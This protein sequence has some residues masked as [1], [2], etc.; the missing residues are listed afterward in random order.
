MDGWVGVR[1]SAPLCI[2]QL[3]LPGLSEIAKH[4]RDNQHKLERRVRTNNQ[5]F[6]QIAILLIEANKNGGLSIQGKV[7]GQAG[8]LFGKADRPRNQLGS[9][10]AR[11]L[12]MVMVVLD[13][14]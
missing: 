4:G 6:P 1:M 7:L 8:D 3:A 5:S 9:L 12:C 10:R 11:I 2:C 13:V 14:C